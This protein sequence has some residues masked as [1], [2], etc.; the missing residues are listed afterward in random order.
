[1]RA[2]VSMTSY[3]GNFYEIGGKVYFGELTFIP[4]ASYLKYKY[5]NT[6]FEFGKLLHL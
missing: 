3:P 4:A 2:I 1:M 6:D 5:S